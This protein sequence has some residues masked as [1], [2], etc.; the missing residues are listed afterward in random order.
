MKNGQV[1]VIC[2]TI[3]ASAILVSG[4]NVLAGAIAAARPAPRR[5][6]W[7]SRGAKAECIAMMPKAKGDPYFV[8][9][10]AGA[11]EA[12]QRARRRA[13]LGRPDR[14]RCR[15]AERGRRELDH[16]RRRRDCRRASRTGPASPTVLRK[17]RARG[18]R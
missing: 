4:T 6:W 8:S 12:A 14:P 18:I 17:A 3:L 7:R 10:R 1:A 13:H 15:Q 9:C 2:A 5:S 11:E 16:A